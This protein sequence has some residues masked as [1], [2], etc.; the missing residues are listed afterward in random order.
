MTDSDGF[1]YPTPTASPLQDWRQYIPLLLA[2][3]D[4]S[5]DRVDV[6]EESDADSALG[7]IEDLK[8]WLTEL[9]LITIPIG[10]ILPFAGVGDLPAGFLLCDGSEL[11]QSEY[12]SLYAAIGDQ[13]GT[14][15]AGNF[16]VP[17]LLAR[18]PLGYDS[19]RPVGTTGG[20]ETHTLSI[21]EMPAHSHGLRVNVQAFTSTNGQIARGDGATALV[22]RNTLSTGGGLA[23]NNMPPFLTLSYIIRAV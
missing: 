8:V 11:S 14:A 23:H 15:G 1:R 7:Y 22:D 16:R 6:W 21:G 2:A 18:F 19:M 3:V 9:T 20:A 4:E 5:L 12:A 17:N 13:F 10:G